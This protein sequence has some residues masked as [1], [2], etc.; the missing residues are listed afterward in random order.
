MKVKSSTLKQQR[1]SAELEL[2][3]ETFGRAMRDAN[4]PYISSLPE[5]Q[6]ALAPLFTL[7]MSEAWRLYVVF[8]RS[9][10]E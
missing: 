2:I 6:H 3:I 5:Y 1:E 4:R 7:N 10:P 8:C 9:H